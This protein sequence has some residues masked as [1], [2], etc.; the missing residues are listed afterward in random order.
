MSTQGGGAGNVGMY[1]GRDML[2]SVPEDRRGD[3]P[4]DGVTIAYDLDAD[5][6]ADL[7]TFSQTMYGPSRGQVVYLRDGDALVPAF[8]VAGDWR[9]VRIDQAG[10][11]LRF[12]TPVPEGLEQRVH[13]DAL[14][15]VIAADGVN[16]K[17]RDRYAATSSRRISVKLLRIGEFRRLRPETL[18]GI[19]APGSGA[20]GMRFPARARV[21]IDEMA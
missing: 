8:A 6:R 1:V 13:D 21:C 9:D 14:D 19:G 10:V 3:G 20:P 15:L 11:T 18:S 16:G 12:E 2:A 4:P 5:G 7:V 17:L